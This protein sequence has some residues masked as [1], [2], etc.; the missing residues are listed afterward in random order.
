MKNTTSIL[1]TLCPELSTEKINEIAQETAFIQRTQKKIL[2]EDFLS[3]LC[4]ESIKGTVSYNDLA[5]KVSIENNNSASRQAY[6]YKIKEETLCFFKEVLAHIMKIKNKLEGIKEI[7][8]NNKFKRIVVQD[9]TIIK[10]PQ[11]LFN[12]FSGISNGN[13]H[14]CNARIQGSYDLLSGKFTSFSVDSFS[15][16]D[17]KAVAEI[18]V[19]EKDL[20]LLDRGYFSMEA[21]Q[22]IMNSK[23]D[24]IF[25]Y[26]HHTLF[27][28][29]E[30]KKEIDLLKELKKNNRL[31]MKILIGK[32][33]NMLVRIL[34]CP[35][36]DELANF[37]RKE[38]IKTYKRFTCSKKYLELLKWNIFIT[39][40]QDSEISYK[41]IDSLYGFRWRIECIFKTWKSN[42]N[43]SK[44]HNVSEIQLRVLLYAR[45]IMLTLLYEKLYTPLEEVIFKTHKKFLSLMK[46]MNYIN[47][48]MLSFIALYINKKTKSQAILNLLKYC[49]FETR[50]RKNY[51]E[52]FINFEIW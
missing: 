47:K 7:K 17:L 41:Q 25:R 24:F 10:L 45:F 40:I 4:Q 3:C 5:A 23:A 44:L 19:Q 20:V 6:F 32:N 1:Q 38:A 14:A 30:T 13:S 26:K 50:N 16:N 46:F 35:V 2:S 48:N 8:L 36:S 49:T 27:F 34:A 31:D 9:S 18:D 42:F 12:S 22:K 11:R 52:L 37:R 33:K 21:I 43:F 39:S 15:K 51:N 28:D 29:P